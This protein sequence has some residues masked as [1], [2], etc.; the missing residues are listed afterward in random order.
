MKKFMKGCA[1]TA[2]VLLIVGGLMATIAAAIKGP[3]TIREIVSAATGGRLHFDS[4]D[5]VNFDKW[6]YTWKWNEKDAFYDIDTDVI[7]D[8]GYDILNGNLGKTDLGKNIQKMDI[9]VAGCVLDIRPSENDN[10]Y[11][12]ADRANKIQYYVKDGKLYVKSTNRLSHW[13][14]YYKCNIVLYVP[15][16]DFLEKVEIDLGAGAVNAGTL[17]ADKVELEADAGAVEVEYLK[18]N[19]CSVKVGAGEIIIDDMRI[20]KLEAEVGMGYLEAYGKIDGNVNAECSMGSVSLELNNRE[21]EFNYRL[22][23]AMGNIFLEDNSY[24]GLAH[25]KTINN[26]A[27][28]NM[29]LECAMGNIEIYF[30]R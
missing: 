12:K 14:D 28:K 23:T 17:V 7:F 16:G 9:K 19:D 24:S 20:G 13:D 5:F 29:E 2:L 21:E 4:R 15:E 27:G 8:N 3:A 18:T 6:G 25:E 11:I 26:G 22:E 10:F 30:N 1:I